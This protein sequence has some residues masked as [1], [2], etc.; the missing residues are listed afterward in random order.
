VDIFNPC[1]RLPI[2]ALHLLLLGYHRAVDPYYSDLLFTMRCYR[3]RLRPHA[4]RKEVILSH[5]IFDDAMNV[6]SDLSIKVK[7][8]YPIVAHI[9]IQSSQ[10]NVNKCKLPSFSDLKEI[11]YFP[12]SLFLPVGCQNR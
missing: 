11:C 6:L 7:K 10:N 5:H 9:Q 4:E 1:S 3:H 12:M 8:S 2:Y